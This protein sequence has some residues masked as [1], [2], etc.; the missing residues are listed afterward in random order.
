MRIAMLVSMIAA[1]VPAAGC[2]SASAH[3]PVRMAVGPASSVAGADPFPTPSAGLKIQIA[4]GEEMSLEKL[5]DEFSRVTGQTLLITENTCQALKASPTGLNRSVDV[6]ASEVYAFVEN[7][8]AHNQHV[9][10][11]LSDHEP[12]LLA[13]HNLAH[14]R[15][16]NRSLSDLAQYVPVANIGLYARHPA[17]LVT[18]MI[19]LP[20]T[21]VR[22]LSNSLRG[23]LSDTVTQQI[24]AVGNT[25]ALVLGGSGTSV[26]NL[27]TVLRECDEGAK[28]AFDAHQKERER[29]RKEREESRAK[30]DGKEEAPK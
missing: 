16:G 17:V 15:N 3:Q 29:E 14:L 19:E 2:A 23:L 13:V 21:D 11:V 8:L 24:I 10:E 9:L 7:V 4:P 6:P 12:R 18:T 30:S 26:A 20:S 28:R 25:N 5:L 27:V 22:T 1:F